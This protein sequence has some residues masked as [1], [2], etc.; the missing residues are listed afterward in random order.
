M[1]KNCKRALLPETSYMYIHFLRKGMDVEPKID[2]TYER[3]Y[4]LNVLEEEDRCNRCSYC[5]FVFKLKECLEN[6][7]FFSTHNT[8]KYWNVKHENQCINVV[9]ILDGAVQN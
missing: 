2:T 1:N 9:P 5:K 8:V 4:L 6:N 7:G 3:I